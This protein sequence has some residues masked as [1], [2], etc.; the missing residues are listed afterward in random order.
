[1]GWLGI[2]QFTIG[3]RAI[4]SLLYRLLASSHVIFLHL[5]AWRLRIKAF[6]HRRYFRWLRLIV[7]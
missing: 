7:K 3:F 1:M 5:Q 2:G 6:R 4:L